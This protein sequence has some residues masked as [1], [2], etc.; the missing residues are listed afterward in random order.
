MLKPVAEGVRVRRSEFCQTNTVV[1]DGDAGVLLVDPGILD[2]ELSTIA[3]ELSAAGQPVAAGFAT[4]PH[5]D[6]VL[7]HPGFGSAPRFA[8][9][10][11]AAAIE[12]FL[13][14]AAWRE[15]VAPMIPADIAERVPLTLFGEL[16]ALPE[17]AEWIPWDGPRARV[18]EHRAHAAGHAALL[19]EERGV[20]V[21]G[22]L[23]SDV[24]VPLVD[25]SAE[26]PIEDYLAALTLLEG[27]ADG[28]EVVVPGHGSVTGPDGLRER[29]DLDR[30][31]LLALRDGRDPL[32]DPRLGPD[33][34]YDWVA[35]VHERQ[36]VLLARR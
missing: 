7:W 19:I 27:I 16:T 25:H 21:A 1:V 36:A 22:D 32:G 28:V 30:A 33:A 23:L 13:A 29:I 2:G 11:A 5:W 12:A 34:V 8:T 4:H 20:L 10:R 18:V 9:A 15:R 3:G 31:Y 35:G 14:D 24:L 17:R 26:E 6:H